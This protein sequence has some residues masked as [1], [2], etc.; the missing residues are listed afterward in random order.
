M[1]FNSAFK[2]LIG[3]SMGKKI[4]RV[5]VTEKIFI[6]RN[7]HYCAEVSEQE[8]QFECI[9]T[10]SVYLSIKTFIVLLLIII[11]GN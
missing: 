7:E 4:Q 9:Y 2:G 8:E 5:D 1:G 11:F 10:I 6:T 3:K